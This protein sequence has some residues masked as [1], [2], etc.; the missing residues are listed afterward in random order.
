MSNNSEN[1][2]KLAPVIFTG[3]SFLILLSRFIIGCE[4]LE[5]WENKASLNYISSPCFFDYK[6]L[7]VDRVLEF[8]F[9][10][11]FFQCSFFR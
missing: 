10:Y 11:E 9:L 1:K 7:C 2:T 8:L 4:V 6:A 5:Y 3:F